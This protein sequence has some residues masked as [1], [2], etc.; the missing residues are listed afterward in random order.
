M[1]CVEC[2]ADPPGE[3][4]CLDRFHA[5]LA[6]D[7]GGV[8]EAARMHGLAVLTYHLQHPS[9]TRPWYQAAGY[10]A[11]RQIFTQDR[12]WLEVLRALN[13]EESAAQWKSRFAAE[14][15]PEVVTNPVPGEVTIAD[16]DPA[17]PP[18][19][20]ERVLAWARSVARHR[21]L[22]DDSAAHP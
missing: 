22:V 16:I 5:L 9:R 8:P 10:E 17:A 6:S 18:G 13:R 1:K 11:M 7:Y 19:H 2:G 3:E 4:T 21:V 14:V 20:T 15:P 12:D